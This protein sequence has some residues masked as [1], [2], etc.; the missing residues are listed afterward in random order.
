M[1][2]FAIFFPLEVAVAA[3]AVVH[4]ANNVLKVVVFGRGADWNVVARFAVPAILCAF[5][6]AAALGL[7]AGGM[8][9]VR[10]TLGDH[11]AVVT[12]L[13]LLMAVLDGRVRAV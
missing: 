11:E 12:P 6:G 5:L 1:P 13:K 3:T 4:G 8:P 10:Y 7:L 9:L 2:V